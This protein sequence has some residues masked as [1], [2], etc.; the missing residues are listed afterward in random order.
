MSRLSRLFASLVVGSGLAVAA[1]ATDS[2][3]FS[4]DVDDDA[5][6][7]DASV[8]DTNAPD[9]PQVED[10]GGDVPVNPGNVC[11]NGKRTGN[12]ECDD[13]NLVD[14]DGCSS[15]C[16]I[17]RASPADYCPGEAITLTPAAG[18][19]Q[20]LRGSVTGT[21]AGAYNH[22]GS[23]CGG[24]SG[25]DVVY[26]INPT[27]SGKAK[28][29]VTAGFAAIISTRTSCSDAQSEAGCQGIQSTGGGTATLEVPVFGGAP[30]FIVV[31]GYGG[32]SGDFTLDVEVSSAVCGNGIA[33]LPEQC[34]DGNMTT[35]DGCSSECTLE[36][37][38][39]VDNCPGQPFLLTGAPGA[40]RKMSFAGN[41]ALQGA[42]TQQ[43]VGCFY[44]AGPNMVYALKSDVNGS[45]A[46]HLTAGYTKANLHARSD[47]G[48]S[49][50]QLGC[51]QREEPG[52][53]DLEFPVSAG[54]WFYLF[55]E[56]HRASNTDY[57]G[58]FTLDVTVTPSACGNGL[59]DGNEQCD[60]GNVADGD[61]CS[62]TCQLEPR[63]AAGTCP[64]DP[65]TLVDRGDGTRA[66]TI[67]GTTVGASNKFSGCGSASASAPDV[68]YA[69]TP[70]VDGLLTAN[71]KGAFN[72]I[73]YVQSS[74]TDSASRVACS[75]NAN[76]TTDP[77]ILDGLG[78]APKSV[79][80]PVVANTTYYVFVDSAVGSGTPSGGAFKLDLSLTPAVCGNGIIEGAEQCD[81]GGTENDDGC[82][83]T[84]QVETHGPKT[85][86]AAEAVTLTPTGAPGT[87]SATL[88]RGTTGYNAA[89]NFTTTTNHV[90]Q[91]P[92]REAYFAVTAPAA[93]ILRA[94]VQSTALDAVLGFR[95]PCATSGTPLACGNAAPKGS[96]EELSMPIA[97]NET[98]WVIVDTASA[99][100]FGRFTLD[101]EI[102][103]S[104]CGDGFF[105]PSPDEQ[106]DDG[107]TVSGDGCSA[108]CKL[109]TIAGAD[110][111]PGVLM[112]LTGAGLQPRKGAM[113]FDT[114][115][116]TPDYVSACGGNARDAVVRVVPNT[117][118]LLSAQI[119]N[120]PG[121][122]VHART[123]C[124][125]PTT[126]L[127]KSSS[128]TCPN[129]VHDFIQFPVLANKEYFLFVDGLDGVAGVS[130]LDVTIVP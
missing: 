105:V 60:D 58:P 41:T 123:T 27:S 106:C 8:A 25:R 64:G 73:V 2:E 36:G 11:G 87:Y 120:L 121:G 34:D 111:C 82:S 63:P 108:T 100:D 10:D 31:D 104:G 99:T 113:T 13:G 50:Y 96:L 55:V 42:P 83:S 44:W 70:D 84:C 78:S 52:G 33:E 35:G 17:E 76:A 129:V 115:P 71:V 92:G 62:A 57:A 20:L 39:V 119:K 109:E 98:L 7:T 37:G 9:G 6:T 128:S 95:K 97:A 68:V 110:T 26:T 47:C 91:A 59:L 24:G 38:G 67:A 107:N 16:K 80:A 122:L 23:A 86:A 22:L 126:E 30:T 5:G 14:N 21:T 65:L 79:T 29:T 15:T 18:Q 74:C 81:D 94:K 46:A 124:T 72:T 19:A 28:V 103:P 4:S 66:A 40:V 116:L 12:E 127:K 89:H 51:V 53:L 3:A 32:T 93:G 85:C 112:T 101:L 1:C 48:A 75:Y 125:D 49:T 77:Y 130:T 118:G 90:C 45:V 54:Q 69:V 117:N 56:G 102:T 43:S 61:G 88:A 114:T